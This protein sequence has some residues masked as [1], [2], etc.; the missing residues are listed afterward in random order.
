MPVE[1]T[2]VHTMP[3]ESRGSAPNL[4]YKERF[5]VII[6]AN[7]KPTASVDFVSAECRGKE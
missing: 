6:D 3:I 2:W 7:G 5:R 4:L 1:W